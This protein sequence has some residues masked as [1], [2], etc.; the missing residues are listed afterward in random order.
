MTRTRATNYAV[1]GTMPNFGLGH[2]PKFPHPIAY[3]L[4]PQCLED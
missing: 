1:Q 4:T 3:Y 2:V